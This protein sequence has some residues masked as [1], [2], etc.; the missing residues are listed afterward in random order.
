MKKD[1]LA[2]L[3]LIADDRHCDYIGVNCRDGVGYS[4]DLKRLEKDELVVIT[5]EH[6][7]PLPHIRT[8]VA[9]LTE[10]GRKFLIRWDKE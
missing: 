7:G 1:R 9:R 6:F 2:I 4:H 5:R 8:T 3:K 10:K